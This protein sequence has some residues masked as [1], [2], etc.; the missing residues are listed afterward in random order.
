M[1]TTPF[2]STV[3]DY[4]G[5][6]R[7][8]QIDGIRGLAII[9][10]VAGHTLGGH[11]YGVGV[12]I[13]F[14]TSGFLITTLLLREERR[15]GSIDIRGFY[16]RRA[17][18]L[19]PV[20][21]V[22]LVVFSALV[23]AGLAENPG[24]WDRRLVYFLTLQN[25]FAGAGTFGHT[26]T[27]AVQ[28]KFYVIWPLAAFTV[29]FLVRRRTWL[30]VFTA[31]ALLVLWAWR[32]EAYPTVYLPLVLGCG[33]ALLLDTPAGLTAARH[34]AR[35]TVFAS[36]ALGTVVVHLI[37]RTGGAVSIPFSLGVAALFP[38]LL[39]GPAPLRAALGI[40]ALSFVGVRAYSVYL[41]HPLVISA[42]DYIVPTHQPHAW[43]QVLRFLTVVLGSVA[44]AAL[45]YR[46]VEKPL[47]E[48]GRQLTR[49][50]RPHGTESPSQPERGR[51]DLPGIT[52]T[53]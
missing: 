39:L 44:L 9:F 51:P 20:Y 13:F 42:F 8:G 1:S 18:R 41:L 50:Q 15:R 47:A 21:L 34:L 38:G 23:A 53:G 26:W 35:P 45:S 22:S 2:P 19:L 16:I 3:D 14:V 32:P 40:G 29:A 46:A 7:F 43:F 4:R 27:L 52:A 10:V 5:T 33:L 17:Y 30:T 49:G 36:L 11:F 48:R 28:E 6:S 37:D 25:E 24:D 31:V 12:P